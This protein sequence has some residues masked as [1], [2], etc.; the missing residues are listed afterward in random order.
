LGAPLEKIVVIPGWVELSAVDSRV[1]AAGFRAAHNLGGK[2]VILFA[3]RLLPVKGLN[4]LIE[5]ARLAQT[6]PTV[7]IIGD[8]APGYAGCKESLVQQ[9]KRLGLGEQ[10]LFLGRF[11][12][13]DLEAGYEAADLFVLP[14]LGEGLPLALLEAMAHGRCI[15]ATDVPG[16]RDV[17]TDGVNGALVEARN[18]EALARK[19]DE[20]LADDNLRTSLGAQARRD[21][22]QNYNSSVVLNKIL[23]VYREV[24]KNSHS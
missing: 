10:V 17:V 7:A 2:R 3:G 6:R 5:A 11:A 20:L 8:E 9:V 4:Y 22:E 23:D 24:Q 1:D 16:N 14:S 21:V 13:E 12:R 18:P 19:I 15:L